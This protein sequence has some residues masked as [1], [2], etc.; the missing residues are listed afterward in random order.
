M[1]YQIYCRENPLQMLI[2][3]EEAINF[4][5]RTQHKIDNEKLVVRLKY[6]YLFMRL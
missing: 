6:E 3:R 1:E 2:Q 4:S 5:K